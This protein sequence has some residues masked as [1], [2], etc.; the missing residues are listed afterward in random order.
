MAGDGG[1]GAG[2]NGRTL[3][4]AVVIFVL[5]LGAFGCA[6]HDNP[7]GPRRFPS[8]HYASCMKRCQALGPGQN[9]ERR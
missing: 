4:R 6:D 5:G 2:W 8:Y 7:R 3:T 1:R 9:H